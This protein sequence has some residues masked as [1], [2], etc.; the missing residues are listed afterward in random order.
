MFQQSRQ[1]TARRSL[2]AR[3][4]SAAAFLELFRKAARQLGAEWAPSAGDDVQG[5]QPSCNTHSRSPAPGRSYDDLLMTIPARR[6]M[7]EVV[8]TRYRR[9]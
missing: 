3:A 2:R 8:R 4:E 9:P 5:H 6:A 7:V 1:L